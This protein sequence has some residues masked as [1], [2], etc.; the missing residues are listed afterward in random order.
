MCRVKCSC[1]LASN[2]HDRLPVFNSSLFFRNFCSPNY[3]EPRT[4]LRKS[5]VRSFGR[6]SG[7][8]VVFSDWTSPRSRD[9]DVIGSRGSRA[10]WARNIGAR[11]DRKITWTLTVGDASFRSMRSTI[12]RTVSNLRHATN[13]RIYFANTEGEGVRAREY[14]LTRE[15][16]LRLF[17]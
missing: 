3:E 2:G 8:L 12:T 1:N 11:I 13:V 6:N 7:I 9:R 16:K 10:D 17:R 15:K 5:N 4:K 14:G